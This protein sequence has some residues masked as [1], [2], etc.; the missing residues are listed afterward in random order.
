MRPAGEE[1][2]FLEQVRARPDDDA[3]RLIYADYL[4][5]RGD[6]RGE[7]I[8]LQCALAELPPTDPDRARLAAREQE[9][10]E[11][12]GAEWAGAVPR[13]V[14]GWEFRR[15]FI[16]EVAL[17]AGA[18]LES[19][20]E[21]FRLTPLRRVRLYGAAEFLDRLV[22]APELAR[23]RE[24]DLCGGEL[25]NAGVNLL[26]RSPH[27]ANLELL[28]LSF[29]GVSDA[30]VQI[31]AR[32]GNLPSLRRLYLN[33]NARIGAAGARA[34][35]GSAPLRGLTVLDLSANAIDSTAVQALTAGAAL[36]NLGVLQLHTNEIG[37]KG[38]AAL[39][40][41]AL[42]GRLLRHSPRLDL[43]DN[44]IRPAGARALAGSEFAPLVRVLDLGENH[45]GSDGV[46]ELTRAAGLSGL[47]TLVLRQNRIDDAGAIALAEWP[48]LEQLEHL[49]LSDNPLTATGLEALRGS[50]FL[51]WR[52]VL[53]APRL[54]DWMPRSLRR[55]RRRRT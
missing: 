22:Q 10:R 47:R 54:T 8:R 29:N 13:L 16:E 26:V 24:L 5:E 38:A 33:D 52:M 11:R 36:G 46:E 17:P 28:D 34:L 27:L 6:P 14:S 39:A 4:E 55:R 45:L 20:A 53:E 1:R 15:G 43:H 12:H 2:A 31:L 41:S 25:G 7:F 37:D 44:A 9:L 49:D 51:N 21:L 23:V 42:L 40:G 48:L 50:A 18:F 30:G 3:P 32:A 19:A 35:A